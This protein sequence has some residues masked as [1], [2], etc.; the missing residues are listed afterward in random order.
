MSPQQVLQVS[1][2]MK[3]QCNDQFRNELGEFDSSEIEIEWFNCN[4]K[5]EEWKKEHMP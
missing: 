4:N 1:E 5:A 3:E 2:K